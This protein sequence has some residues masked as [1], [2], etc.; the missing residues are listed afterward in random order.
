MAMVVAV[1]TSK[2]KGTSKT[3]VERAVVDV[4]HGLRGDAHADNASHRQVSL[5]AMESIRKMEEAGLTLTPGAFA[6]NLTTEGINLCSLPVGTRLSVG[7]A[8]VLEVSQ[9]GKECHT[10]CA[11]YHKVGQCIMPQEGVFARVLRGGVVKPGDAIQV[12]DSNGQDVEGSHT[13]PGL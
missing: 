3:P 7:E 13:D 9:I 8:V 1:C 2:K 11:I 4:G 6:E 5:L 10:R 12:I